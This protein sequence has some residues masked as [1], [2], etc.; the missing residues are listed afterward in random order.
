[1]ESAPT[2]LL[3]TP[4]ELIAAKAASGYNGFDS[5]STPGQAGSPLSVYS[6]ASPRE[7]DVSRGLRHFKGEGVPQDLPLAA[8]LFA[9]AAAKGDATAQWLLGIMHKKGYGIPENSQKGVWFLELAAAQGHPGAQWLLGRLLDAGD[10][11]ETDK[12]RAGELFDAVSA[13]GGYSKR[14]FQKMLLGIMHYEGIGMPVNRARAQQIWDEVCLHVRL[15][16]CTGIR[17]QSLML[18]SLPF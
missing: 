7:E 5:G 15:W 16:C 9:S 6:P 17:I 2:V 1:M 8:N 4:Q 3:P 11:V 18:A 12:V 14:M 13:P 10:G